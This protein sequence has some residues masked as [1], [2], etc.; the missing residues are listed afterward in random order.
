VSALPVFLDPFSWRKV[1][2]VAALF[3]SPFAQLVP[4]DEADALYDR[5]IIPT[6]ARSAGTA[7]STRSPIE[8]MIRP[9]LLLIAGSK[10]SSPTRQ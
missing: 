1:T 2:Y 9:L 5:Y 6:P 7:S 8:S 10:D 4:K 3:P